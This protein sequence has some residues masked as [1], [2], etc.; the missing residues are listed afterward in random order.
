MSDDKKK[1]A[2]LIVAG[3]RKP[4]SE[5]QP[6]PES[7]DTS[8]HEVAADEI[9]SAVQA[10]DPKALSEALKSFVEMCMSYDDEEQSE[11]EQEAE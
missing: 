3:L 5:P 2:T 11:P 4:E 10:K 9:L 8:G 6:Q 7:E 1:M